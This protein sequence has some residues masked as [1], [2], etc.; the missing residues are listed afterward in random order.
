MFEEIGSLCFSCE[1]SGRFARE[2][3]ALTLKQL[4]VIGDNSGRR[5]SN[6]P[7]G[8]DAEDKKHWP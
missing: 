1:I 5:R 7:L 2:I 6:K 3:V 4:V 8:D